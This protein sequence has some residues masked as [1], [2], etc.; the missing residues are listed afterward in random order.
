MSDLAALR[1]MVDSLRDALWAVRQHEMNGDG[2]PCW[3]HGRDE[4]PHD[5]ACESAR[6]A[7]REYSNWVWSLRSARWDQWP[8]PAPTPSSKESTP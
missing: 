2:S 4:V 1:R 6:E 3:C 8:E 7:L 5:P